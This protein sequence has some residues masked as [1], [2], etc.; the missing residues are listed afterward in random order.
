MRRGLLQDRRGISSAA[1]AAL[2][3]IA[4]LL[5]YMRALSS[6]QGSEEAFFSA[7]G[8]IKW[9]A[10]S[11]GAKD[12]FGDFEEFIKDLQG[13]P[14]W[15]LAVTILA[16]SL[17]GFSIWTTYYGTRVTVGATTR[18]WAWA[19]GV[20]ARKQR[21]REVIAKSDIRLDKGTARKLRGLKLPKRTT[22]RS[23]GPKEE[24]GA[25]TEEPFWRRLSRTEWW[26]L[27]RAQLITLEEG[28]LK[29]LILE[30]KGLYPTKDAP[31]GSIT[32]LAR[33]SGIDSAIL[34]RAMNQGDYSMTEGNLENSSAHF[35][36]LST[37]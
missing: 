17:M 25:G 14:F 13:T 37:N 32:E 31:D 12:L 18:L 16:C 23:R 9:L 15:T 5:V 3:S 4:V 1:V 6:P 29:G 2:L 21:E 7:F 34:C 26:D 35:G 22:F 33:W 11:L 27:R 24:L 28:V 30:A 19:G 36:C 8:F 10:E 20:R